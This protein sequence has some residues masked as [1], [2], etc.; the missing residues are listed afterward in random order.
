ME[1]VTA[2][3]KEHS[4]AFRSPCPGNT[5]L[6]EKAPSPR[7]RPSQQVSA[8]TGTLAYSFKLLIYWQEKKPSPQQSAK[9]RGPGDLGMGAAHPTPISEWLKCFHFCFCFAQCSILGG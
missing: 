4:C 3:V 5:G 1:T 9:A 2:T 7:F 6:L 8:G